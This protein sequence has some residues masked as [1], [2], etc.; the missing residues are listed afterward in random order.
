[1]PWQ[2]TWQRLTGNYWQRLTLPKFQSTLSIALYQFNFII[3]L[4]RRPSGT[5]NFG[6]KKPIFCGKIVK[7]YA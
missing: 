6:L 2:L 1:M 4:P 3:L 5:L 7:Q